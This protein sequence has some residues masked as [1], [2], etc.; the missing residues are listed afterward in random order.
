[1]N[2]L[3]FALLD[4]RAAFHARVIYCYILFLGCHDSVSL[5]HLALAEE[6]ALICVGRKERLL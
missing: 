2:K 3:Q 4:C 6:S 5:L 1:M